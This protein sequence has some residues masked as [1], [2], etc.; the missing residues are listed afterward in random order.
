MPRLNDSGT[1]LDM[2]DVPVPRRIGKLMPGESLRLTVP[3][4]LHTLAPGLGQDSLLKISLD[5][6]ETISVSISSDDQGELTMNFAR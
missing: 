2:S 6:G 3:P 5:G 4:G 1:F